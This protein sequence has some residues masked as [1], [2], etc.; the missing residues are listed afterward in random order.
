MIPYLN[1]PV[2]YIIMPRPLSIEPTPR[3]LT[4]CPPGAVFFGIYRQVLAGAIF[5][6]CWPALRQPNISPAALFDS[7]LEVG[8]CIPQPS[9][10]LGNRRVG[11]EQVRHGESVFPP[12]LILVE[13]IN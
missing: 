11:G 8:L 6:C 5:K 2:D 7:V 10:P 1:E 4:I 9:H 12:V 13:G 3:L